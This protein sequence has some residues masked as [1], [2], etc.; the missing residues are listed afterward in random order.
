MIGAR[1]SCHASR[2]DVRE[3]GMDVGFG[4]HSEA[5]R[6]AKIAAGDRR[7]ARID[8]HAASTEQIGCELVL[9]R[10][11]RTDA[12]NEGSLLDI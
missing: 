8:D 2:D 1:L 9:G 7:I 6:V 4:H 11:V 10:A 3:L 12:R 5:D